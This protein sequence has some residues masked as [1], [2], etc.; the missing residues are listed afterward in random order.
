MLSAFCEV[1]AIGE[2]E[3]A[4]RDREQPQPDRVDPDDVH[5]EERQARVDDGHNGAGLQHLGQPLELRRGARHRDHG[6]D[7]GGSDHARCDGG[8]ERC[9]PAEGTRRSADRGEHPEDRDEHDRSEQVLADV[10]QDLDDRLAR[11]QEAN[12]RAG[13]HR[14]DVGRRVDEEQADHRRQL[15][16]R[17]GVGLLPER[18]DDDLGFGEEE[19]HREDGPRNRERRL[20]RGQAHHDLGV[21]DDAQGAQDEREDRDGAASRSRHSCQPP[22]ERGSLRAEVDLRPPHRERNRGGDTCA[23]EHVAN[24]ENVRQWQPMRHREAIDEEIERRSGCSHAVRVA[25]TQAPS[26]PLERGL[27]R[28]HVAAVCHDRREI[29]GR[30]QGDQREAAELSVPHHNGQHC[31]GRGHVEH[32]PDAV[33]Q[34]CPER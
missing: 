7:R 34:R 32:R 23:D 1:G 26:N 29:R 17:K 22:H 18:H 20:D 25:L 24:A 31:P 6:R 4:E 16:Q 15:A 33:R 11:E 3:H 9:D 19:G 30:T 27:C 5:G 13:D 14:N 10:E 2:E 28:R 8:R 12:E 21:A